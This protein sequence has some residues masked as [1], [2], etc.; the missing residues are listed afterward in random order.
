MN[1]DHDSDQQPTPA[2]GTSI[3]HSALRNG[4]R[5]RSIDLEMVRLVALLCGGNAARAGSA[6]SGPVI[7]F[8]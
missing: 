2:S 1:A 8:E 6:L 7:T 5:G 3:H 4:D